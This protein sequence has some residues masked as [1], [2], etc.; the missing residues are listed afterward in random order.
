VSDCSTEPSKSNYDKLTKAAQ[1]FYTWH[2]T[3]IYGANLQ[4]VTAAV[5]YK[6][7]DTGKVD[8]KYNIYVEWDIEA[9]FKDAA[10]APDRHK[11]CESLIR[12]DLMKMLVDYIRT[13]KAT[14]FQDSIAIF[15]QQVN[16]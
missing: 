4:S 5:H 12:L 16:S 1:E 9:T 15:T 3:N 2:L 8:P 14:P 6:E 10:T 11:L 7:F 13:I